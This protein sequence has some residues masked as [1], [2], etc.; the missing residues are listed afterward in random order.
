MPTLCLNMI[1]KNESKII[2]RLLETVLPIIDS[3]CICDT[4]STDNTKDLI[5][6]FFKERNIPGEVFEE[7][8][9]NFGYNR[10]VALSRADKWADYALLLDADMKLVI[11]PDFRKSLLVDDGYMLLQGSDAFEYS[12][13][14]IVKTKIGVKCV[15]PTHE[16]YDFPS[17]AKQQRWGRNVMWI[18]DI[19][20]GGCK[21]DKFERDIRL[22]KQGL[23]EDPTNGRYHF[24]IAN[25]Y[26]DLGQ[27]QEAIEWY[28][29][30]IAIGGWV[31]EVWNSM[32]E[33]GKC[34]MALKDIPNAE[35]WLLEAY[36]FRPQRVESLYELVRYY[37]ENSKHQIGQLLC[38]KARATPYPKDDLLFLKKDVY[39]YLLEYEHSILAFYTK[40]PIDYKKYLFLLGTGHHRENVISNYQF[41]VK[42][43]KD[44]GGLL[45]SKVMNETVE[46]TVRG[47]L[48][49]FKSSSPC[50]I[51]FG[52]GYV[53]NIRYVNYN[54]DKQHGSYSYRHDDQKIITLNKYVMLTRDLTVR[55][56][57]WLDKVHRT[58]I[59]YLGVEDVKIFFHDGEVRFLGTV[60]D[61]EGRPRVGGGVYNLKSDVLVPEVY[62]SPLNNGC[63]KNWVH[64]HYNGE[65]KTIYQWS[66]ITVGTIQDGAFV[67]QQK[68]E[69]VPPFFR[70]VRGST[71]GV[72]VGNEL[73]FLGH[74][75]GYSSP[76]QY[77]HL[78][79]V[80]DA[81]T[82]Q[83][84]RYSNMFKFDGEKIEYAL[85]LVVEDDRI[86]ISYSR[87]DAE[88][89]LAVYDRKTLCEAVDI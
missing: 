64:F 27:K 30:R 70:D 74:I 45:T 65:L 25:S 77:Y 42:N 54:L 69:D 87:W 10:S 14:R 2:T 73:W 37:R 89:V 22:L 40:A 82:L 36:N 60:Q 26:R 66:P 43:L 1:V 46:R 17:G 35:H 61:E 21:S 52:D 79:I 33:M 78:F 38:D 67:A 41:Y 58:D 20:D 55:K 19:G 86:L 53:M 56:E 18:H 59:R 4:G 24:Y 85:G 39:D 71:N 84:K 48:D 62:P 83:V 15:C 57:H 51:P 72:I 50:I 31:E 88:S 68:V 5:Q 16:Y 44:V 63:E 8:F 6:T 9:K 75:V 29:K 49:T 28:K 81:K 7:P 76:R 80:L 12:N 11:G 13:L 3:Y 47:K 34:Y 23:E 32:Y